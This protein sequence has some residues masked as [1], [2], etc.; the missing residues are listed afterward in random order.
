MESENEND[1]EDILFGEKMIE[2]VLYSKI[3]F[4]LKIFWL[5][6]FTICNDLTSFIRLFCFLNFECTVIVSATTIFSHDELCS[7]CWCHHDYFCSVFITQCPHFHQKRSMC[8][9]IHFILNGYVFINDFISWFS[10][11]LNIFYFLFILWIYL[12]SFLF[13]WKSKKDHFSMNFF[14]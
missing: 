8:C 6:S 9:I 13:S 4:N 14:G 12:L 5:N 1:N 3:I 7:A 11:F 2:V 10:S